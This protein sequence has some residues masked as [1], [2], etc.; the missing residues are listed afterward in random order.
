M[1]DKDTQK[2]L[3]EIHT[4]IVGSIDGKQKGV[5]E[6]LNILEHFKDSFQKWMGVVVGTAVTNVG[7]LITQ[8]ILIYIK[9]G[10]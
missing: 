1:E 6:R 10:N 3:M 8:L 5:Y 2:L 4:A 7:V 9:R